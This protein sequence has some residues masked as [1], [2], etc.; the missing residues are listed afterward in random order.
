MSLAKA[1]HQRYAMGKQLEQCPQNV[2]KRNAYTCEYGLPNTDR[3]SNKLRKFMSNIPFLY[4]FYS[5]IMEPLAMV[6]ANIYKQFWL[7]YILIFL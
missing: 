1:N 2:D 3:V 7:A 6:W 5:K 4:K